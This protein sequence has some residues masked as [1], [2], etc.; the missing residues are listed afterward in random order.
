[1]LQHDDAFVAVTD[2]GRFVGAL[3]LDGLHRAMRRVA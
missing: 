3:T 1:M 2:G